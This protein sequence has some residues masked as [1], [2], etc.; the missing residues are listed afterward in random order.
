MSKKKRV[1]T[2][3]HSGDMGDIIF[4]LP[5]IRALGGGVLYL[6]PKGGEKE[7]LVRWGNGAYN[8]TKLTEKSIESIKELLEYQEYI[9]EVKLWN[10]EVVDFN[11]DKFRHHIK[12][13]NLAD[14]H[15]AAFAIDFEERDT[16]WIKVPSKIVDDPER[17][18]IVARSCRYHGNYTFW[19]TFDRNMIKKATYL[20]WEKEFEY[21]KY[22]Y[23]HFGEV[24]RKEVQNVL[25]MAQVIAGAGL[26]IGNQGLPHALAEALKKNV[27]NEV[28][29][30]YPAAVFH[31]EDAKYV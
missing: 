6:D 2:Y 13:N 18:V 14:S 19:E 7:D 25:E 17:D 26:F 16:P 5:A 3:K 22:T 28:Y 11:L 8:N 15:L 24:P 12:Y 20:G 9:K 29:R 1:K 10:G 27:I 23:P 21:F 30:P 4:S 31:R